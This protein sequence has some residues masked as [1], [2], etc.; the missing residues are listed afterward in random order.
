MAYEGTYDVII[1]GAGPGGYVS[2]IRAS[3]LG[4][5]VCVVEK[6]KCGGICLHWGCIPSKNLIHQAQVFQSR[7][8]LEEM[9]IAVNTE[10]FDYAMVH[11]KSRMAPQRL[12][13]GIEFLLKK[14]K[15][16]LVRGTAQIISRDSVRLSDG[17]VINGKNIVIATGS[18]SAE[19]SGF[20][21]DENR[22]M[23]ST[24][25]LSMTKLPGSLIILGGGAIGC[26][27]AY[28]MNA[29]GVK[30][31]LVEMESHIL[32][33]EDDDIAAILEKSFKQ[34]KIDVLT[35]TRAVSLKKTDKAVEVT[36]QGSD[37]KQQIIGAEKALCVFGRTPNTEDIGLD[38]IGLKTEKG[39][40]PVG[41]YYETPVKGIFAIG[42]VVAT[43]LLAHVASK[44][45]EIA[46]EYIAG[47]KPQPRIDLDAVPSAIYCEPQVAGFG[48]RESQAK[49]KKIPYK[50]SLFPYQ[51]IGKAV[52]VGR[53]EGVAKLLYDPQT[54]EILGCHIIGCDA[55]ELIHEILLAK[56]SGLFPKDVARMVH[57]HPTVSEIVME[58]MKNVNGEAIH[59]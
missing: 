25:I 4:L 15:V 2:G 43:P 57:A 40:I 32:P 47:H 27:F 29:F 21:F 46:V 56:S 8:E 20:E 11:K 54:Q 39:Y 35:N 50:K 41:D 5:K 14:N 7:R 1:I 48:L 33:F 9:G 22:V 12:N 6:D 42:D 49:E 51:G 59:C 31:T 37:A 58:V 38:G 52:A 13:A 3:Q 16:D 19:L 26:E 17:K 34:S 30:V 24:G 55:T 53:P 23:S 36:L 28:I 10:N 45:G 18:R 44:E